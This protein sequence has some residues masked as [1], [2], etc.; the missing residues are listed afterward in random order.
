[1][2]KLLKDVMHNNGWKIKPD[3]KSL[4]HESVCPLWEQL[5]GMSSVACF[6]HYTLK[7]A[8]LSLHW[9]APVIYS[10]EVVQWAEKLSNTIRIA[11]AK[12]REIARNER[13][14]SFALKRANKQ[15]MATINRITNMIVIAPKTDHEDVDGGTEGGED[16]CGDYDIYEEI[17]TEFNDE[18]DS[19]I[20]EDVITEFNGEDEAQ[21]CVVDCI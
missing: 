14:R 15:E 19:Q 1:M 12:W 21:D 9:E 3:L 13:T 20:F 16:I 6:A 8:M 2:I 10:H 18:D 5:I 17:M 7:M 11:L 4:C